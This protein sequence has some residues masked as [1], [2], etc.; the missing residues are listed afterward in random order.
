M[1]PMAGDD[2]AYFR[3]LHAALK[4]AGIAW[5]V[6]LIDRDRLDENL[7]SVASIMRDGKTLRI[8][9]KSLSSPDL[10]RH[11]TGKLGTD[12]LMT[13]STAMLKQLHAAL[14]DMQHLFGKPVPA[15]AIAALLEEGERTLV[16]KTVWLADTVDRLSQYEAL[17]AGQSLTLKVA[18]EI[19]VGLHRGGFH[20]DGDLGPALQLINGSQSLTY[21]GSVGYEPHLPAVPAAFGIR[22]R[23]ERAFRSTYE[24]AQ[25]VAA[26]VLGP[27]AV[28]NAIVNSA[29][30]KT[31][32]DRMEDAFVNDLSIGSLLLKPLDF[33]KVARPAVKPAAF[34]ATPLLKKVARFEIPGFGSTRIL[35]ML[36]DGGAREAVYIHGGHWLADPVFP[37]GLRYSKLVGRSSNQEIL[38][39]NGPV[40]AA[41]D[42]TVFLRPHQSE[43]VLLQFGALVVISGG[44]VVDR[45]DV[46]PPTA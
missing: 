5:P 1:P 36:A 29:G 13:F 16:E 46:F 26:D 40:E 33:D 3:A 35:Q 38:V 43:A 10:L 20:P 18:L 9:A 28:R 24:R 22:G 23:A 8:V 25:A 32:A 17:A 21:A 37:P 41:V 11:V 44:A 39:S 12:R 15:A 42:D 6:M 2:A 34:I 30:S 4:E 45:W 31:F 14:P 7:A 19:D 27:D